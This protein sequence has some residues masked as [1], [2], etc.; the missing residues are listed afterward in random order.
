MSSNVQFSLFQVP[1]NL[2]VSHL[3]D[4]CAIDISLERGI[5]GRGRGGCAHLFAILIEKQHDY[6]FIC[7]VSIAVQNL[8]LWC[9]FDHNW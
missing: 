5:I 1:Y 8:P 6:V 9:C 2:G 3:G 7:L 4:R